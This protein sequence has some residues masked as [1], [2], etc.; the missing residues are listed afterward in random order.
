MPITD[1][2]LTNGTASSLHEATE[3]TDSKMIIRPPDYE[4]V[5]GSSFNQLEAAWLQHIM[6][7]P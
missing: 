2:Q 4:G 5:Y 1:Q 6:A 3:V 7:Q